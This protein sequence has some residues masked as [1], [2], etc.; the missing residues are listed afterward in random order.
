MASL[1]D[2]IDPSTDVMT[3]FAV[4][5]PGLGW[6]YA[7]CVFA[8]HQTDTF[9]ENEIAKLRPDEAS[10]AKDDGKGK[11]KYAPVL[12]TMALDVLVAM[13]DSGLVESA[14]A[15]SWNKTSDRSTGY[16][17]DES[18]T[19]ARVKALSVK[20]PRPHETFA[21]IK[22]KFKA[23]QPGLSGVLPRLQKTSSALSLVLSKTEAEREA[24]GGR[25][26]RSSAIKSTFL[27]GFR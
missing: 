23:V 8:H 17:D 14:P 13:T 11:S 9:A 10:A 3:P 21:S 20:R 7:A 12:D 19:S 26:S 25:Q 5:V 18:D 24:R 4:A 1:H 6:G 27:K 16:V 22:R 2:P 15:V